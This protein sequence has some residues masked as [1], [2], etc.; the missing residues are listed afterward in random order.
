MKFSVLDIILTKYL[1]K[2]RLW[3]ES[4]FG[5]KNSNNVGLRTE[6]PNCLNCHRDS[7]YNNMLHNNES[8]MPARDRPHYLWRAAIYS[9]KVLYTYILPNRNLRVTL[10]CVGFI[11]F[12]NCALLAPST[13]KLRRVDKETNPIH[14]RVSFVIF[15]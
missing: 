7:D 13:H 2:Y 11:H 14:S 1:K 3:G 5:A 6:F 12:T 8:T 10:P 9:I 15:F 4:T